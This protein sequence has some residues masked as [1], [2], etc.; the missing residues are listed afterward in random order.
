M[1]VQSSANLFFEL[2]SNAT[3]HIFSSIERTSV[4]VRGF[5]FSARGL[6]C[7]ISMYQQCCT[8]TNKTCKNELSYSTTSRK[9]RT[10]RVNPHSLSLWRLFRL[11]HT[12]QLFDVSTFSILFILKSYIHLI[13]F[14]NT[15]E[16]KLIL[17][18]LIW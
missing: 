17:I 12:I 4:C 11:N 9:I 5:I 3:K 14:I 2:A 13:K 1:F 18:V 6:S 16:R 8:D 10:N 7:L 15:P